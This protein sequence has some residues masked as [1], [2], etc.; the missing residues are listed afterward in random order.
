MK[1]DASIFLMIAVLLILVG[2]PKHSNEL[3]LFENSYFS[4]V[5]EC[6]KTGNVTSTNVE[7]II[8][9][10]IPNGVHSI[11]RYVYN[12]EYNSFSP[13]LI[14]R[15][16]LKNETLKVEYNIDNAK[17]SKVIYENYINNNSYTL[18]FQPD[19]KH[20]FTISC[21]GD[22]TLNLHTKNVNEQKKIFI[23]MH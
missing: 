4:I 14:Y 16:K 1:K 6:I 22:N 2:T 18:M 10:E 7:K 17:I 21:S 11:K 20:T 13:S 15:Y 19:D 5:N 8:N 3:S 9:K 12:G 23:L